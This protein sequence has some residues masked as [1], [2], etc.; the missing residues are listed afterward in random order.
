MDDFF[1]DLMLWNL[2]NRAANAQMIAEMQLRAQVDPEF[3][4]RVKQYY[5]QLEWDAI[6]QQN[7]RKEK[8]KAFNDW[9][10]RLPDLSILTTQQ[11]FFEKHYSKKK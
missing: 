4:E 8:E 5:R 1:D 9:L 10:D 3:A 7:K 2:A 6:N 11:S